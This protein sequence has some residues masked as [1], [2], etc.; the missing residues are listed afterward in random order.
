MLPRFALAVVALMG[1]FGLAACN[2]SQQSSASLDA[3]ASADD[4]TPPDYHLPPGAACTGVVDRYE[5]IVYGDNQT[6]MVS[7]SVFNEIKGE[8]ANAA[9]LCRAGHDAEARAAV[10]AS[11]RKHGYPSSA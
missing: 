1:A 8:I 3:G 5:T 7:T 11:Q 9:D 2:A 6:G 4:T 10:A